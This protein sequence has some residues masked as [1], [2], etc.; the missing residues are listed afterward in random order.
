MLK[1]FHSVRACY[2]QR[3]SRGKLRS[4]QWF[5]FDT[6]TVGGSNPNEA[7]WLPI[8]VEK[9]KLIIIAVKRV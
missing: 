6:R 1:V 9:L 8:R 2:T 7:G 4:R 5:H 3:E